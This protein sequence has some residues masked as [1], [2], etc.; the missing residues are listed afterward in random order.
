DAQGRALEQRKLWR[1]RNND[2]RAGKRRS[3][4]AGIL[5]AAAEGDDELRV[6]PGARGGDGLEDEVLPVLQ[7]SHRGVDERTAVE[8]FPRECDLIG[9]PRIM[10]GTGVVKAIGQRLARKIEESRL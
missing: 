10:P 5:I 7:R 4:R 1:K 9:A 6:E 8:L 3:E 2:R